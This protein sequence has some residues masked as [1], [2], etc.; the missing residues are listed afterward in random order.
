MPPQRPFLLYLRSR[1]HRGVSIAAGCLLLLDVAFLRPHVFL[2]GAIVILGYAAVTALLF[3]SRA[4]VRQVATEIDQD[5]TSH[6]RQKIDAVA[7]VRQQVA[8]LRIGDEQV[9]GAVE[10]F[11]QE[12][13]AYLE[14]CRRLS[15]YSP[16]ANDRISRVLDICQVFLDERDQGA[17]ARRYQTGAAPAPDTP[18]SLA[19][20]IRECATVIRARITED[21]QGTSGSDRLKIVKELEEK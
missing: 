9:A 12:S 3:F 1:L 6:A 18:A 11:L 19:A 21:L 7:A 15:T 4:G 2:A 17:T 5:M 10:Y 16:V 8:V 13:G 14:E 20:E